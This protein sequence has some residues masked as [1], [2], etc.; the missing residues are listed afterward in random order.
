MADATMRIPLNRMPKNEILTSSFRDPSGFLFRHEG[1][2]YRQ[3]N[4]IYQAQYQHLMDSGLYQALVDKTLLVPHEEVETV[5]PPDP[6]NAALVLKPEELAFISYPYEWCFSQLKDAALT[7]LQ[8]QKMAL[9]HGMSL[10]D[11][12]AYNIQFDL[13]TGRPV[14]IDTLSFEM[15]PE[16]RPWVAYRQF[17]Q[18]F[19]A[20]LALM[21]LKDIRLNQLLRVYLDGVPLDLC[22]ELLPFKSRLSFGLLTHI[23]AHAAAQKRYAGKGRSPSEFTRQMSMQSLL[24]L[25]DSLERTVSKLRWAPVGTEWSGYIDDHNYS[26][27]ALVEKRSL[28]G[29]IL[30]QIQPE[31]VWDLGANTGLYSRMASTLGVPTIAFDIDPGAVERNYLQVKGEKRAKLLPLVLDL[32]NPSPG[33]GWEHAE[34]ESLMARGPAGAVLALALIHH[35]AIANNLPLAKTAAFF[36]ALS[37]WLVIEFVPKSDS[38]VQ[39]LLA[40]REDI[41]REYTRTGFEQAYRRFYDIRAAEK[42]PE[43]KR[44]LYWMERKTVG[45]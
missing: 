24:G 30:A 6:D 9:K 26:D 20:P 42:I 4:L 14:L 22:S 41:F 12:S 36:A 7:T 8:I 29:G 45:E 38:Q 35:L 39:R 3:V 11:S 34:R 1:E 16:G 15:Y 21:V 40:S 43:S 28:V 31:S 25:I 18:H 17:C 32:T 13:Q 27:T 2:L 37:R 33:L 23:H 44:V 19:L 10:K 5:P